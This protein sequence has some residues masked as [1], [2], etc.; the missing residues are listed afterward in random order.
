MK[1]NKSHLNLLKRKA[2]Y[3]WQYKIKQSYHLLN[4]IIF[5]TATGF[6]VDSLFAAF[7]II[8]FRANPFFSFFSPPW[9]IALWTNF[10]IILYVFFNKYFL[11]CRLMFLLSLIGFPLAYA[12][13]VGLG[14]ASLLKGYISLFIIAITWAFVLPAL[15]YSYGKYFLG[16]EN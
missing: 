5:V 14:A 6:I 12:A 10:S 11:R 15:L 4:L 7:K 2:Q 9:M 8:L 1:I 13:G 3:Y 16:E